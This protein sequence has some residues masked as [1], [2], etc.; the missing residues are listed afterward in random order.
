MKAIA[1][2]ILKSLL[3]LIEGKKVQNN[4]AETSNKKESNKQKWLKRNKW[5]FPSNK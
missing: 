5:G 4:S 3:N 2:K 1:I